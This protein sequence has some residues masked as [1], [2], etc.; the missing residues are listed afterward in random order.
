MGE[1]CLKAQEKYDMMYQNVFGCIENTHLKIVYKRVF[2]SIL[3][4]IS[5][6]PE[7]RTLAPSILSSVA[8]SLLS[9][10]SQLQDNCSHTK[11]HV[12][13]Q[14]HVSL[15]YQEGTYFPEVLPQLTGQSCVTW[16]NMRERNLCS[17]SNPVSSILLWQPRQSNTSKK[18]SHAVL[19]SKVGLY[20]I[21]DQYKL[22]EFQ[23]LWHRSDVHFSSHFVWMVH[24]HALTPAPIAKDKSFRV[25]Y[26]SFLINIPLV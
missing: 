22:E 18:K 3:V 17:L 14:Q 13:M 1:D 19:L 5:V 10:P 7:S 16:P 26:F 25:F 11:R 15:C 20:I 2:L 23:E 24:K 12:L 21:N 4:F 8:L 6:S 9:P